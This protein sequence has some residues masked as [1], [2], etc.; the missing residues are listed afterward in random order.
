MQ[1]LAEFCCVAG[2]IIIFIAGAY[3]NKTENKTYVEIQTVGFLLSLP[4]FIWMLL[5]GKRY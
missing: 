3:Y 2:V 4:A 1:F 5:Y